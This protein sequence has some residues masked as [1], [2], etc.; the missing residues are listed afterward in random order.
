M[1]DDKIK[2]MLNGGINRISVGVQSFN[3]DELKKIG[4]I[5]DA[6]T[7]YNTICHL[8]KMGFQNIN[9]DLMTALP[10]QTFE[11]LKNT[12]NTAVSLPVKHI[13]A[14]SLIIEDGSPIEKE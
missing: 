12:L 4:R 9:L 8:D 11:S 3:D 13:S 2:A 10:S 14:Y 5:H 7:A 1:D 6:K